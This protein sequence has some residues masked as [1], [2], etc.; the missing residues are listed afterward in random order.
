[1][2]ITDLPDGRNVLMG[3]EWTVTQLWVALIQV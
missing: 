3:T 2:R 1:M